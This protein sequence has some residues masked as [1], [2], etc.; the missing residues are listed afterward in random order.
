M[1]SPVGSG[2]LA[3]KPADA[4]GNSINGQDEKVKGLTHDATLPEIPSSPPPGPSST[5]FRA[6]GT[7][8]D[9]EKDGAKSD[10]EAE[11]IVLPG[12][13]S[14]ASPNKRKQIKHEDETGGR[15]LALSE[16]QDV[17]MDD[18]GSREELGIQPNAEAPTDDHNVGREGTSR[19]AGN[20]SDLSSAL[21]SPAAGTHSSKKDNSETDQSRSSPPRAAVQAAP[22]IIPQLPRKRKID[23]RDVDV[24]GGKPQHD[25]WPNRTPESAAATNNERRESQGSTTREPSPGAIPSHQ[26]ASR[27]RSHSPRVRVYRKSKSHATV[28]LANGNSQKR[29]RVPAPLQTSSENKSSYD[30]HSDDSSSNGSPHA[31]PQLIEHMSEASSAMSPVKVPPKKRVDQHGRTPLAR[32][33]AA[34]PPGDLEKQLQD[35]PEDIDFADYA[36]NTPLQTA[37][38]EG[39]EAI[40]KILIDHGCDVNC[41]NNDK[42]TPLIDAVENGHLEVV[43]LLLDAGADPRQGNVNGEEPLD[44]L[45]SDN[46]SSEAIKAV[47]EAAKSNSALRRSSQD[48]N[49]QTIT[50]AKESGRSSRDVSVPSPRHSPTLAT[51][52]SPPSV[53]LPPRRKTVRSEA[54]RNDLLWMKPT[55]E[56]LRDRAGKGDLAGVVNILNVLNH[57]AD[58]E[59]LI[60]AARGGHDEVMQ[61][62][63]SIG[64]AHPDPSPSPRLRPGWDTPMLAAIGRGNEKVIRLL[65]AQPKFNPVR[66]EHWGPPYHEIAKERQG[67]HWETEYRILKEAY[68]K[69]AFARRKPQ[70]SASPSPDS[71]QPTRDEEKNVK[72]PRQQSSEYSQTRRPS[73]RSKERA[74]ARRENSQLHGSTKAVKA[75]STERVGPSRDQSNQNFT[76]G[77]DNSKLN[78]DIHAKSL[79]VSDRDLAVLGPPKNKM[80]KGKRS[81]SDAAVAE[82]SEGDVAKPRR[83]LVSGKIYKGDQERRRRASVISTASEGSFKTSPSL[84]KGRVKLKSEPQEG[85]KGD[86]DVNLPPAL[87]KNSASD[88]ELHENG[89]STR[90]RP[91]KAE[92]SKNR[93][94]LVRGEGGQKRPRSSASPPRSSSRDSTPRPGEN[95]DFKKKR[96]RLETEDARKSH[97]RAGDDVSKG[98]DGQS[99]NPSGRLSSGDSV[100]PK[101][102]TSP[103]AGRTHRQ[104]KTRSSTEN[105]SVHLDVAKD[106]PGDNRGEKRAPK[107]QPDYGTSPPNGETSETKGHVNDTIRVS[108]DEGGNSDS[109][110][111]ASAR[112]KDEN[113]RN[114]QLLR[115][116]AEQIKRQRAEEEARIKREEEE[117]HRKKAEAD[118]EAER[119]KRLQAE[120]DEADRKAHI[121]REEEESR[122]ADRRKLE[123]A[124]RQARVAREEE[125]ARLEKK[126]REEEQQRRRAEQER[127]RREE[128]ERRRVEHE[129]RQRLELLQRQEEQERAR[130]EALPH[131]LQ[132]IAELSP[133]Q[134]RTPDEAA[135]VLPLFSVTLK[136]LDPDCSADQEEEVWVS[137]FQAAMILGEKDLALSRCEPST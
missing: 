55:T 93:L 97:L 124:E 88:S 47:L 73:S 71:P 110:E 102:Q 59:S 26:H 27:E 120:K 84:K 52:R 121:A 50:T 79:S 95:D 39:K 86:L 76:S 68:D 118:A 45:D 36:G 122:A 1:S 18:M 63:L 105:T 60:A 135:D 29:K 67:L 53:S 56:N 72:R 22:Q 16:A 111:T 77:Q 57:E 123:E 37:S 92:Q 90:D 82:I 134:S 4:P 61:I 62:L 5:D 107:A 98:S 80:G 106:R 136:Q 11:T 127:L 17:V 65:L 69:Q 91:A 46:D 44:L 133:H 117:E 130:R 33:C 66:R 83:K 94:K 78:N 119:A 51:P 137:N 41:K 19:E 31:R 104:S 10:S 109:P 49:V 42:D 24:E 21:S 100:I 43:K 81:G 101:T 8:G 58:T 23:D 85:S 38:L 48:Q 112:L 9:S 132:R 2:V 6:N 54:T 99:M 13:E 108:G 12:K 131:A 70:A 89:V 115:E 3:S 128:A 28:N 116:Q 15:D 40:V 20:S 7:N 75:G 35:R 14:D 129:E 74:L 125:Q 25:V 34:D 103:S 64:C 87:L 126:R 114:E 30:G 113:E 96:R 32:V